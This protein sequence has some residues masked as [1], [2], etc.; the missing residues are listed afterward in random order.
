[1]VVVL[2]LPVVIIQKELGDKRV[3]KVFSQVTVRIFVIIEI[4]KTF[5]TSVHCKE[6]ATP[7]KIADTWARH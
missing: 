1:M 5:G 2:G 7:S 6:L 3:D 4:F